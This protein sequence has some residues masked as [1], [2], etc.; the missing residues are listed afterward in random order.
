M[1]L[2]RNDPFYV[3]EP[4]L[5]RF[6]RSPTYAAF[7]VAKGIYNAGRAYAYLAAARG[8]KRARLPPTPEPSP[9]RSVEVPARM[10]RRTM[11]RRRRFGR[12]Y[13]RYGRR[14]YQSSVSTE[15]RDASMSYV[16]SRMPRAKKR[17]WK[18]FSRKFESAL[19]RTQPLQSAVYND[20][21]IVKSSA[22]ATGA[23]VANRVAIFSA[24]LYC[25]AADAVQDGPPPTAAGHR[26]S[27]T[28][29]GEI[30]DIFNAA[31][32]SVNFDSYKLMF[33]TACMDITITN[34]D[35][36]A[37]GM[38][39]LDVYKIVNKYDNNTNT[40]IRADYFTNLEEQDTSGIGGYSSGQICTNVGITP[41][42]N[43]NFC[44]RWKILSKRSMVIQPSDSVRVQLRDTRNHWVLGKIM[45]VN[46]GYYPKLGYGYLFIARGSVN[47]TIPTETPIG[48]FGNT[49]SVSLLVNVSKTYQYYLPPNTK[50]R[51]SIVN[52]DV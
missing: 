25:I 26:Y 44:K 32:G 52:T 9:E 34:N 12:R 30:K 48:R 43:P 38:V 31:Y 40:T 4:R 10:P 1:D 5:A 17:I 35:S 29:N 24:G 13:R 41:F 36:N 20:L 33:R 42:Q 28:G 16:K 45:N 23:A 2:E 46:S 18:S 51:D 22:G 3:R 14:K 19:L 8:S 11:Y 21:Q 50:L 39:F 49:R 6:R 47:S 15:Q 37:Q 7:G 27:E